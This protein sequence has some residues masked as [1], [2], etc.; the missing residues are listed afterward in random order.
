V[1]PPSREGR[2]S[3]GDPAVPDPVE[4]GH[5]IANELPPD[6]APAR[7]A[8]AAATRSGASS[9]GKCPTPKSSVNVA[10]GTSLGPAPDGPLPIG[11][12]RLA[13]K[14]PAGAPQRLAAARAPID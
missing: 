14:S 8:I 5:P 7:L 12:L 13:D 2:L 3:V 1:T 11:D 4:R 10:L 6:Q 9:C